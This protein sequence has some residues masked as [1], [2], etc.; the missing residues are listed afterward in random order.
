MWS[1]IGARPSYCGSYSAWVLRMGSSHAVQGA[2]RPLPAHS[3][4][5]AS[6]GSTPPST[7][8]RT[9]SANGL[10]NCTLQ[11]SGEHSPRWGGCATLSSGSARR[12][13]VV[14][15]ILGHG[16]SHALLGVGGAH[17]AD[18]GDTRERPRGY[19]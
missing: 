12:A 5:G 6:R 9:I 10:G 11:G 8:P 1:R 4:T 13:S 17:Q 19:S 14:R 16:P 2:P 3:F 18:Q 15:V 7:L